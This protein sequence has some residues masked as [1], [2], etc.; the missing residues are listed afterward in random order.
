MDPELGPAMDP[1][2][3]PA[4]DPELGPTMDPLRKR[5]SHMQTQITVN[6]CHASDMPV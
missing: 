6:K 1:E 5:S 4:M 3:G 2:P